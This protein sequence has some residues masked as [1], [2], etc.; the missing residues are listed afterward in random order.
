MKKTNFDEYTEQYNVILNKQLKFFEPGTEYFAEYKIMLIRQTIKREPT[1]ILDYGCGVGN[2]L[3]FLVKLFP[4]AGIHGCDI[5][6]GSL[7]VAASKNPSVHLFLSGDKEPA[8]HDKFDLIVVANVFHHIAHEQRMKIFHR[9]NNWLEPGGALFVFEHNPYNPVTR[10]LVR[11]CP[12][13]EDA[14]L[15]K[16]KEMESSLIKAGFIIIKKKYVLFF[17]SFLNT[18]RR[19]EKYMGGIP[20]GGQYYIEA[21]KALK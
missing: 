6:E 3:P 13:D 17:P 12:Y 7:Q 2:N 20:L 14:V 18:L 5:S 11:I 9:L 4:D 10:H 19:I 8:L 15:L 1:R 21:M 16:P